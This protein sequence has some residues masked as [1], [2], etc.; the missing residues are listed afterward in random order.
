ML[1]AAAGPFRAALEHM[2]CGADSEIG[3]DTLIHLYMRT[4]AA[5]PGCRS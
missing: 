3:I 5:N 4:L 2:R 1:E